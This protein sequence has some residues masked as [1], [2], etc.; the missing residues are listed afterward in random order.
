MS[1]STPEE[2]RNE[3]YAVQV[4]REPGCK[5]TFNITITPKKT[6]ELYRKAI[7]TI[8]K[9]VVLP[10]FRKG[11]APDD[12]I[13][14]KYR[15]AVERAWKE[16][17]L[18]TSFHEAMKLTDLYPFRKDSVKSAK[19]NSISKTEDSTVTIEFEAMPKVPEVSFEGIS[20]PAVEAEPVKEEKI[21]QIIEDI[22]YQFA[23]WSEITDRAVQ[24]GDFVDLDILSLDN[25]AE[26]DLK[27]TRVEVVKGKIGQWL[28]DLL[29]GMK[30]GEVKEGQSAQEAGKETP[31]FK[32]T[33]L[34]LTA[35]S[36]HLS[37]LPEI[38]DELAKKAGAES[39]TA[40]KERIGKDL[41][42]A[43]VKQAIDKRRQNL[44]DALIERNPFEVPDSLVTKTAFQMVSH[45]LEKLAEA[46]GEDK[47]T[48]EAV[49][50][51]EKNVN[52]D[53]K[54]YYQW[55]FITHQ[56]AEKEKLV[57][58]QKEILGEVMQRHYLKSNGEQQN[59]KTMEEMFAEASSHLLAMK[60]ADFFLEKLEGASRA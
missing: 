55:Q 6:N 41:E 44:I 46:R 38:N 56:I 13:V 31:E 23:E 58:P 45:R 26:L 10:G 59:E 22:R 47:L 16:E 50:E 4:T 24:E 11:K 17:T 53:V 35:N 57:V 29:I 51:I 2:F 15:D 42:K 34:R 7:K 9:E 39:L 28:H 48:G 19:I 21:N 20:I 1:T 3:N 32:P 12:F 27:D 33:N 52:E 14:S 54:K 37:T 25:P 5:T 60:T 30:K 40:M 36:I 49:E 43:H 8:N 18:E